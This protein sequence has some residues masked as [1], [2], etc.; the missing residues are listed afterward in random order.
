MGLIEKKSVF[1]TLET[2]QNV[3]IVCFKINY[4]ICQKGKNKVGDQTA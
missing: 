3:Q 4:N 1:A 2:S